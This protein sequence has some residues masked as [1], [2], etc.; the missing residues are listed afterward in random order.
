MGSASSLMMNSR[1]PLIQRS[2]LVSTLYWPARTRA[3]ALVSDFSLGL[4]LAMSLM[5]MQLWSIADLAG[6]YC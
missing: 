4:F 6:H 1:I 5:S 2:K 3:L